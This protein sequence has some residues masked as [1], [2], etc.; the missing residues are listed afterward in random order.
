MNAPTCYGGLGVLDLKV[1]GFAVRLRWEWLHRSCPNLSWCSLPRKPE[2]E[3][4]AMFQASVTVA[5]GDGLSAKFWIDSWLPDGPICR[6]A[7]LL[8]NTIE[9]R[10]RQ[11]FVHEAIINRSWVRNI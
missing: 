10:R 2:C 3:V 1:A 8:F 9:K 4:Q 6:F 5:T 7:P 11:K